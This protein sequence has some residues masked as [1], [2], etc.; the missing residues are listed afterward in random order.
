MLLR[1]LPPV[2]SVCLDSADNYLAVLRFFS[3]FASKNDVFYWQFDNFG[4]FLP[5]VS[6][7]MSENPPNCFKTGTNIGRMTDIADD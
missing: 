1:L 4:A 5:K 2:F 7:S 6:D 3:R